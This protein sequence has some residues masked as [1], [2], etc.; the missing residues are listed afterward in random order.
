MKKIFKYRQNVTIH[1]TNNGVLHFEGPWHIAYVDEDIAA[2]RSVESLKKFTSFDEVYGECWKWPELVPDRTLFKNRPYIK[3]IYDCSFRIYG[4]NFI[5]AE[6]F[7]EYTEGRQGMTIKEL[8]NELPA[9]MFIEYVMDKSGGM[10]DGT[11]FMEN[12]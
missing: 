11:H 10:F 5:E 9:S 2:Q 6:W 1:T 3:S 7:I 4:H 8:E 12:K